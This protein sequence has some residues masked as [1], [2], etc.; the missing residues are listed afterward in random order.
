MNYRTIAE[1][2]PTCFKFDSIRI[3][4]NDFGYGYSGSQIT[5]VTSSG[6]V[7]NDYITNVNPFVNNLRLGLK[8]TSQERKIKISAY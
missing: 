2:S 7:V 8:D 6:V 1:K 3:A 5:K 4:G